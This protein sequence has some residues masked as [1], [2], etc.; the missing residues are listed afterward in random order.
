VGPNRVAHRAGVAVWHQAG[1]QF[2][3][4][5]KAARS[6]LD[7]RLRGVDQLCTSTIAPRC[8]T[9][10]S[11]ALV[12]TG[13]TVARKRRK[14]P[15]E[16]RLQSNEMFDCCAD[17]K[18]GPRP[19]QLALEGRAIQLAQAE[20]AWFRLG[21]VSRLR[22]RRWGPAAELERQN[23]AHGRRHGDVPEAAADR[24]GR[25]KNGLG[26]Y[27]RGAVSLSAMR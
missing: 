27:S 25:A 20:H 22:P 18:I 2:G 7:K 15:C 12:S 10:A 17:R 4:F 21:Q 1:Q 16:L 13:C 19:K 14:W 9:I 24:D 8:F 26:G 3:Y 5:R 11:R 6:G 23:W